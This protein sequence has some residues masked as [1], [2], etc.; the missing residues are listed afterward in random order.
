MEQI[1]RYKIAYTETAILD[2]EEKADYIAI[3]LRDPVLAERWYMRLR[4]AIQQDL[5]TF[6]LKYPLYG[7]EPWNTRG[8]R[9]FITRSDV[10]LY[11]VDEES[12]TVYIRGVCTRGRD[13]SAHLE[14]T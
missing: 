1:Q 12:H 10:I 4:E 3:Q 6:P 5:T 14:E 8:V 13:L 7:V 2:M 9:L 11:H